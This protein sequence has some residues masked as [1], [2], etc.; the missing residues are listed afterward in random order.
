MAGFKPG[1]GELKE[2]T[3]TPPGDRRRFR[4]WCDEGA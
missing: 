1:H 2:E 4:I 3:K